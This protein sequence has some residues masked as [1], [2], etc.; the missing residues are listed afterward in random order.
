MDDLRVFEK[1]LGVRFKDYS[2]LERSLTHRSYV[3]ERESG[4]RENNE[5][6]EFLGDAVL[7]F[8]VGASLYHRFPEMK[9]G[10]L[11]ELRAALVK[12]KTLADFA[13]QLDLGAFLRLGHGEA[14]NG[15]RERSPTLAGAFEAVVGAVY[16]DQG[17][18]AVKP[19]IERFIGPALE[20]ILAQSL[21][22]DAKSE[23]QVWA[24][25]E[26]GITPQYQTVGSDGPDHAKRF[27]VQVLV[28]KEVWGMGQGSSKQN[29]AQMA[30]GDAM[31]RVQQYEARLRADRLSERGVN[32]VAIKL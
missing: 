24:Q 12:T 20:Q 28:G 9:E 32:G 17:L 16:L 10:A 25:A 27:M 15:G 18:S 26:Y 1:R 5:R 31:A 29:A 21:Q 22:K 19:V 14:E 6:L 2:L 11:T 3:N 30:A 4:G 7:D 13:R 23:F 8:V